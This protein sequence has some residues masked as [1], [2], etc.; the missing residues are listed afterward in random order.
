LKFKEKVAGTWMRRFIRLVL[1]AYCGITPA[2]ADPPLDGY[3]VDHTVRIARLINGGANA[4][5]RGAQGDTPLHWA[6][7]H[8]NE[9]M[10]AQ[11]IARGADVNAAVDNGNTPLHQAAYCGHTG[12]VELLISHGADINA[13]TVLGVTPLGWAKR[14]GHSAVVQVLIAHG[15]RNGV[16]PAESSAP[17]HRQTD[18][19][20]RKDPLPEVISFAALSYLPSLKSMPKRASDA[21]E[22]ELL[23]APQAKPPLEAARFRVQLAAMRSEAQAREMWQQ[24]QT[25]YPAILGSL[26][27]DVESARVNE[28]WFYRVQGGPLTKAAAGRTC[29]ELRRDNQGCIVVRISAMPRR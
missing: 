10:V 25:R 11:L 20:G 15:G 14:N 17:A 4:R 9:T 12:V 7:F 18:D 13:R 27:L 19:A 1:L 26:Q 23:V 21:P 22:T 24:Y 16:T 28:T 6:A 3:A 8:G 5:E 2:A 29:A